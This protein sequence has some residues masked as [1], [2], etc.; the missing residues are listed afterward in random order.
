MLPAENLMIATL[1]A[2]ILIL[3]AAAPVLLSSGLL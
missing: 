1:V 2:A 3:C